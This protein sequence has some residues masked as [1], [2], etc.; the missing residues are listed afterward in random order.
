MVIGVEPCRPGSV[1]LIS[2]KEIR[3]AARAGEGLRH[4]VVRHNA[5]AGHLEGEA[6][7]TNMIV[8]ELGRIPMS[9]FL[10]ATLTRA[11]DYATAQAHREV[12]L[13]HLLLALVEDPEASVVLKSSN[14]ELARLTAEVSDFLGHSVDRVD[15]SEGHP[16]A[17]SHDLKRILEAAAAAA[18]QGRRREING[19]IVL[20]AIVGDGKSTAAH[21]L[22]NQ[23]LTFEEAIRALQKATAAPPPPQQ[24]PAES[25]GPPASTEE[26]LASARER[27]NARTGGDGTSSAP[28]GTDRDG[29]LAPQEYHQPAPLNERFGSQPSPYLE[30]SGSRSARRMARARGASLPAVSAAPGPAPPAPRG[31]EF[32]GAAARSSTC[33]AGPCAPHA[34][35]PSRPAAGAVRHTAASHASGASRAYAVRSAVRTAAGSAVARAA[36]RVAPRSPAAGCSANRK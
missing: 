29:E 25:D 31:S 18:Q 14:V 28:L 32:V 1:K 30:P 3:S 10:T 4:R 17:V 35:A 27:I 33:Q 21:L 20:A 8:D 13:E 34:I 6:A 9:P 7:M 11:A 26:V 23:G 22:R 2:C 19:A 15:P 16:V 5:R 24:R 36:R 12:T